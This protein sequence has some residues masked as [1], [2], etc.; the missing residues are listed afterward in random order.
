MSRFISYCNNL[1]PLSKGAEEDF[2]SKLKTKSFK[3]GDTINKDGQ[4]CR[5]LY[6]IESGLVKHYYFHKGRI[7]IMRFFCEDQIFTSIDSFVTQSP[8]EFM[9]VALEDTLTSYLDYADV[10]ELCK[11]HHSFETFIRKIFTTISLNSL[12]RLKEMFDKDASELYTSFL[13]E[14]QHLLQRVSLG[15]IA[16]FLGISQV[17]LSRIRAKS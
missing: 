10:E 17:S 7:F 9:T 4:I 5:H 15:D 12:K 6:F 13:A 14:N 3:K 16:S 11:R 1:S 8:A 2:L